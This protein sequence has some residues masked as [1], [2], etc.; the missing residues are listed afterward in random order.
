MP[1]TTQTLPLAVY[2]ALETDRQ[3]ALAISLLMVSL[4][5]F[6]VITMRQHWWTHR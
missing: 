4:S 1:G 6:I 3:L 2:G 5:L